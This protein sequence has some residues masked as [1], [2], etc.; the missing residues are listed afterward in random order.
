MSLQATGQ[1]SNEHENQ[2]EKV[3]RKI[4]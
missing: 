4:S 3:V 1:G 2:R